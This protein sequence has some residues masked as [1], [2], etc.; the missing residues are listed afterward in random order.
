M[1]I[2]LDPQAEI[3]AIRTIGLVLSA[4]VTAGFAYLGITV[5]RTRRHAKATR[6]QVENDHTTNLRNDVDGLKRAVTRI[7]EHLGIEN[8]LDANPNRRRP[9]RRLRWRR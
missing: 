2:A 7:E 8:T 6:H 9:R 3:E 1:S 4:L 5:D